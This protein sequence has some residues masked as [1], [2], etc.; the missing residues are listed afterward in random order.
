MSEWAHGDLTARVGAVMIDCADP[1]TLSAFW[2]EITGSEPEFV[3]PDYI[4]M[5]KLAGNHIRLAFQR[6]PEDKVVK[7]R[8]HLDLGYPDPEAFAA[9]VEALGGSILARHEMSGSSWIVLADPAGN[10]FCVTKP[11]D[12]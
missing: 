3:Y 5:T 8:L 12:A 11:H 4:F 10:E 9:H 6:V 1:E 2:A 7:N